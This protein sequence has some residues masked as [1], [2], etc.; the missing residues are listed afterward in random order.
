MG[1]RFDESSP[2]VALTLTYVPSRCDAHVLAE[3]KR[4]SHLPLKIS[5]DDGTEGTYYAAST[6]ELKAQFY[7]FVADACGLS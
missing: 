2:A 7:G 5:L 4:G 1:L 6:P 3:D